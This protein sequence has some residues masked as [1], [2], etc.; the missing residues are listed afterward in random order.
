M[1]PTVTTTYT[2]TCGSAVAS[3][4]VKVQ[5]MNAF[6][7]SATNI[8]HF[9]ATDVK[10]SSATPQANE[11]NDESQRRR[12]IERFKSLIATGYDVLS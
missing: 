7:F 3:A 11:L 2:V 6:W 9:D 10:I 5:G 12:N 1:N 8:E 4:T